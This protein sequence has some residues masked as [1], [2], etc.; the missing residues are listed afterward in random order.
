MSEKIGKREIRCN[1]DEFVKFKIPSGARLTGLVNEPLP[2]GVDLSK[3][4]DPAK[5]ERSSDG[6]RTMVSSRSTFIGTRSISYSGEILLSDRFALD[7]TEIE[8]SKNL[9]NRLI[10]INRATTV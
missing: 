6:A 2:R 3:T 9:K 1:F 10:K 4:L 7:P 8:I 5:F